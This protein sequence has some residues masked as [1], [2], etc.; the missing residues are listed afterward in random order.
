MQKTNKQKP[1]TML[2]HGELSPNISF[3]CQG[4]V[5]SMKGLFSLGC[6]IGSWSLTKS[7]CPAAAQGMCNMTE[8]YSRLCSGRRSASSETLAH[9][10][11]SYNYILLPCEMIRIC[12]AVDY[13]KSTA[14]VHIRLIHCT[15]L[16][17]YDISYPRT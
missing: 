2:T 14:L 1:K 13:M 12:N 16:N 9:I 3:K 4:S 8:V 6:G 10:K 15:K 5:L 7:G 11:N 17:F